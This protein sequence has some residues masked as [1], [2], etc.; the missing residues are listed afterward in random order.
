MGNRLFQEARERVKKAEMLVSEAA[1]PEQLAF[2]YEEISKAKN[3]LSSAF[4][5]S[6]VAE[7]KQLSELQNQL[8]H[9]EQNLPE[10]Q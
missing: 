1:T 8:D 4:A 2:A 5:Q 9:I 10:Y 6:S 7:K 3:N